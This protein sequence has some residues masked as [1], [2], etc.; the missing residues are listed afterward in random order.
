M[1]F[2]SAASLAAYLQEVPV[3]PTARAEFPALLV[4]FGE[5]STLYGYPDNLGNITIGKGNLIPNLAA[6]EALD[7]GDASENEI[8]T[9]WVVLQNAAAKV[10][11]DGP[12]RWPG[13]GHFAGL[14]HIR[15]TQASI[16]ALIETRLDEFDSA[17]RLEWP[18]WDDAPPA[19]QSVLVRLYWAC[20]PRPPHGMTRVGWP[21]L[22]AF[23]CAK[24]WG[25][26]LDDGTVTGCASECAIPALEKT[27]PGANERA[28]DMFL[29]CVP[30]ADTEPAP[31]D[32]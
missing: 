29:S 27:E 30:V 32:S 1:A 23:W 3:D 31:P 11:R 19:A 24:D 10:K 16:D 8:Q 5:G 2:V 6:W 21:K 20:G 25:T 22:W 28:R 7:W 15:A 14:T 12:E 26:R 13:G 18:G 4:E 9:A 17:A